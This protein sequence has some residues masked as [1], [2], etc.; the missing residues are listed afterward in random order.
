ML[1]FESGGK[2]GQG[3]AGIRTT[4]STTVSTPL[5]L[6]LWV[7]DD[8]V[9]K[10]ETE[11]RGQAL[12][13]AWSK[14]RGSGKVVFGVVAPKIDSGGRATTTA[15][16]SEL[17]DYVLRVLAWDASGP[18]ASIMAGGFQCCWTNGYVRVTVSR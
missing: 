12:G 4:L 5:N 2:A 7:T 18:Q 13:V 15:T 1:R 9:R 17:G 10:R 16:F 6:S 3:P 14:F 11:A 8:D